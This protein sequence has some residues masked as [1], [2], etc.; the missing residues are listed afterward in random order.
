MKKAISLIL[1]VA[2]CLLLCVQAFAIENIGASTKSAPEMTGILRGDDG[3]EYSIV[4]KLVSVAPMSQVANN[5]SSATYRYD[6]PISPQ[7]NSSLTESDHDGALASTVY[8]TIHYTHKNTPT[9]YLLTRVSGYWE[10]SDPSV[11]VDSATLS[12]G[13]SGAYP[14][15]TTQSVMD[16]SVS[17]YFN[18]STGFTNYVASVSNGTMGA[19]MT[20][21]YLMGTS[22]RWSFTITNILFNNVM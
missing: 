15:P 6:L 3:R 2:M 18:I 5:V 16:A 12:Y 7:A 21:N 14:R 8:L 17:N 1:A 13:C 11:S 19:T 4:G 9:E 22:R 20:V 10:I